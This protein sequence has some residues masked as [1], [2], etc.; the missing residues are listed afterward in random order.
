M[1]RDIPLQEFALF[2]GLPPEL[3]DRLRTAFSPVTL[4]TGDVLVRQGEPGD[5]LYL[6]LDGTM[7]VH[8]LTEAGSSLKVDSLRPG[9]SVGEM[10]LVAGQERTAT[11]IASSPA[12]L[13]RL[14]SEDFRQLATHN[15]ELRQA[16]VR[17]MEPRLQRVQ[18]S[19]VLDAWFPE[20]S[21]D[22]LHGLQQSVDWVRLA[23]GEALYRQ[24]DPADGMF[25]LVSGRLRVSVAAEDGSDVTRAEI[26]R[27]GSIGEL[28]VLGDAP[29][30]ETVTAMRD[31]LV[32]RVDRDLVRQHPHVMAQIARNA[33]ERADRAGRASGNSVRTITLVPAHAGAPVA[34]VAAILREQLGPSVHL[35]DSRTVDTRFGV[36]GAAQAARGDDLEPA[37]IHWLNETESRH[38]YVL[39][40]TDEADSEWGRRCAGRAD[41][42]L[43]VA[44]A[45]ADPRPGATERQLTEGHPGVQLV[46][47]Q[48]DDT[49]RPS[50]T[51]AWLKERVPLAHHHL[52]LSSRADAGRLIR[53]LTG[54]AIG[55]ALS[56]GG[57]RGYVHLGLIRALEELDIP[58]D[59]VIGT[60]MGALVGGVYAHTL[61]FADCYST[62]AR[63]GDPKLLL[64]KTLPLV[65]LAESRNVTEA[66]QSMF[67]DTLIEDLWIPF[68]CVSANLTRAEP[69]VHDRGPL[70]QAVRASTA[71]PG[72]F[73]PVSLDG[74]V[75]VDGGIMNN[76]P[77]DLLRDRIG[78]GLV[79]GSNAENSSRGTTYDFG[80]SVSG[81][82]LL[83]D[84]FRPRSARKRYPSI[85][86]T[87]MRATS[88]SSKYL[89]AAADA[90]TDVGLRYPVQDF[91][92]LE[93]DRYA[94][95]SEVGYRTALPV[96]EAWQARISPAMSP[97]A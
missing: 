93:F 57:A 12:R 83:L 92:N 75:L 45:A 59:M 44:D 69:M 73:T 34:Q 4:A 11:V 81:W 97:D 9:A 25:L 66:M 40:V 16:V 58:V 77:V 28:A 82:H 26:G 18:L 47:V 6:L 21:P 10:A 95:L 90:L 27:G 89:G 80:P 96:L 13:V 52:R 55:L 19:G 43:V 84:R 32:V 64:D 63:F 51:A 8:V 24:G 42:M 31:S 60:S 37:L 88:V 54:S 46:L 30:T 85:L 17:Q 65:A 39:L 48:P 71:I 72:I 5:A 86:S 35:A 87:L 3:L 67:G 20:L 70:W 91:G 15:P 76:Y 38:S 53:R 94:E 29:R 22:Q 62:A 74:D 79:I 2:A 23:G 68:A 33:L 41:L 1:T 78:T 36:D 56:G 49:V 14:A 50:G 7:D 61:N